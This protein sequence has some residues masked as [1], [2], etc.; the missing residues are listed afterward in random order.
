MRTSLNDS[1]RCKNQVIRGLYVITPEEPD[2]AKLLR[3]VGQA[4]QGG[5]RVV[6]YRNKSADVSLRFEQASALRELAHRYSVPLIVNDD[7]A[8]ALKMDADGVHL[9]SEDGSIGAARKI[10]GGKKIIGVSCYN[11]LK[12]ALEAADAGADYVAFGAFFAS[13]VKPSAPVATPDLL[14][15]ARREISLPLVAI[16]GITVENGTS[17]LSAGADALAVISALFGAQDILLAA[18]QFTNLN[19]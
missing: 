11:Q 6:Q 1:T 12:L 3:Q 15:Q 13:A 10:L 17:L 19:N 4:L 18:G 2:T 7:V 14:R 9:G 5:G 8:L 16:G